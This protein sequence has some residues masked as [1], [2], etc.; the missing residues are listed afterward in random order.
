MADVTI[1]HTDDWRRPPDPY[2]RPAQRDVLDARTAELTFRIG[3][4]LDN[5]YVPTDPSATRADE[6]HYLGGLIDAALLVRTED[7]VL[8]LSDDVVHSLRLTDSDDT[9]AY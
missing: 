9:T 3:H 2:Y 5:P 4:Q 1:A 7:G 6:D 8:T